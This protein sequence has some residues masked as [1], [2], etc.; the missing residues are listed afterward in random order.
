MRSVYGNV[1]ILFAFVHKPLAL[2][3]LHHYVS[4]LLLAVMIAGLTGLPLIKPSPTVEG[5]YP[6]ENC[7]CGCSSAEFCWDKCCCHSDEEKLQWAFENNVIPPAFLVARV[8]QATT[9]VVCN[10]ENATKACCCCSKSAKPS[11]C[12]IQ[13][14]PSSAEQAPQ[15][16][17]TA[18]RM[19]LLADAAKCHGVQWLW[20]IF[21]AATV[22]QPRHSSLR[23]DPPFLY[24]FTIGDIDGVS[25]C[26]SP[27]PPVP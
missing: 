21:T 23:I 4:I 26:D 22:E 16:S 14:A 12:E 20:S 6:C 7:P 3:R 17:S 9:N 13:A 24:S 8:S 27:E 25:R 11:I 10:T 19:V 2:R 18:V 1:P 15:E 5:R